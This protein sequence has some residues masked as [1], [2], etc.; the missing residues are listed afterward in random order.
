[1]NISNWAEPAA[2]Q[3]DRKG[4]YMRKF[5]LTVSLLVVMPTANANPAGS[6]K[7][8]FLDFAEKSGYGQ[9]IAIS[10]GH[11]F[12]IDNAATPVWGNATCPPHDDARIWWVGGVPLTGRT[13]CI[14]IEKDSKAA[15]VFF[16]K[17]QDVV[18]EQWAVEKP[19]RGQ[20]VLRRPNGQYI[21]EAR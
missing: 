21:A 18:S 20:T 8:F 16:K 17:G 9:T 14:V 13:S 2:F 15:L 5:L 19:A 11:K 4:Q 10:A 7:E 12:L 6:L 1:M 3:S